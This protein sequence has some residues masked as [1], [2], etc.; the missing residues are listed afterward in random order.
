MR[1]FW[2]MAPAVLLAT[3]GCR[4]ETTAPADVGPA[5]S[6]A[7]IEATAA[8]AFAQLSGGQDQ[9]TCGVTVDSRI[10]C[11]GRNHHGQLGDGTTGT[12]LR[13]VA[14]TTSL[15]FQQVS[16]GWEHACGITAAHKAYCWGNN[17]IG[18]LGDGTTDDHHT[19]VAV[20]GGHTFRQLDAGTDFTCAV[21]YP[22]NHAW[23]WGNNWA[24]QLGDGTTTTHLTPAAV[25]G[26][27]TF[28]Q[29]RTGADHAC[30]V[31]TTNEAYCWG[32]NQYGRL[33][34]STNVTRKQPTRV[35]AGSVRFRQIDAG[36][37]HTCA[38]T[39][40]DQAYCWGNGRNGALGNGKTIVSFWPRAV[41]GGLSFRR[42]TAGN[43]HTCSET[44]G[45]Q[46]YC[47]GD[48]LRGQLG[49]G[50]ATV[51]LKPAPVTGGLSF[52]QVSAGADYTCGR[53]AAN[54]AYCWGN[55]ILGA[56]GDG[57]WQNTRSSPTLVTGTD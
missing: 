21:S 50:T 37:D 5:A 2:Y 20:A 26:G 8:P 24:G 54:V 22:D 41:L 31:T 42:V 46:A 53:T 6:R 29:V 52:A 27:L 12:R 32:F 57:T 16:S 45:S 17:G 9:N 39:T 35:A 23:C 18:A 40:T 33:G 51:R 30:G 38:V 49:D 15:S 3:L 34:D 47:W 11:W 19:P 13:P 36:G 14:V 28:Q 7:T 55:N 56:L 10:F 43:G 1:P 25:A 48:N 44:L 4:D